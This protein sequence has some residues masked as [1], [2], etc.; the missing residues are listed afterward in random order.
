MKKVISGLIL[1]IAIAIAGSVYYLFTNLDALIE[2]AIEKYGSEATQTS[3]LVDSVK[4]NL[5]DG[6][7]S[8][9]G[10]TVGNPAG[11]NLS[12][13]FSL[14]E[15]R[16][17]IDLQSLQA[18]PYIINEITV[19]A[20]Q[21]FVEINEDNKTNLNELKKNLAASST[22][23]AQDKKSQAP[24]E[25]SAKEPRLII[26]RITFADGTIQARVAALKN[27]EY[28]LKLPSFEMSNLGGSKGATATEIASEILKRLTDRASD[29]VKKDIIDAELNKLKDKA[30]EKIDEEKAKLQD[31]AKSELDKEKD[32][33]KNLF[34]R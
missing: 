24:A 2:A 26:R 20:P 18:E 4:T 34:G 16:I 25:G 5:T 3:V 29:I 1:I 11:Y 21:V 7:A 6:A 31:K 27:K 10:L 12:N 8:I 30:Q 15:I 28:A 14:G 32:K 22:G 9:T 19:L 13:A 17:G 33:L 23:N